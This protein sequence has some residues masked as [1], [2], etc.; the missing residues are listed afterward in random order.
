MARDGEDPALIEAL[1]SA[2]W[3]R[4]VVE[5]GS[6]GTAATAPNLGDDTTAGIL[7]GPYRTLKVAALRPDDPGI[8]VIAD[9]DQLP[10]LLVEIQDVAALRRL[11]DKSSVVRVTKE[12]IDTVP[13]S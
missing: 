13:A 9:Y 5:V 8:R 1:I 7:D 12:R 10:S 4:A 6:V 11:E 3:V 2:A